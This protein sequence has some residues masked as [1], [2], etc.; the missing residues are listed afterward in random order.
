MQNISTKDT[1]LLVF[2]LSAGREAER[3]PLFGTKKKKVSS[4]F[5]KLL[6]KDTA[7]LAE[8]S[9]V[10]VFWIDE[11]KQRGDDFA[12]RFTHAFEDLYAKGY[13]NVLSIGNDC[14]ELTIDRLKTAIAQLKQNK[15]VLGPAEDGGAYLLGFP[16]EHFDGF[17]FKELPW[18]QDDLYEEILLHTKLNG[19]AYHCLD[20]LADIDS[21]KDVLAFAERNPASVAAQYIRQQLLQQYS[22]FTT[23]ISVNY[24]ETYTPSLPAR[25][26]PRLQMTA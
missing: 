6:I 26:P 17:P 22:S 12:S 25:A 14:P 5:F 23:Y 15:T 20:P 7:L 19:T 11:N 4:D 16:K 3:K 13:A 9:G 8:A 1:A 24:T 21:Q 2:S 18:Q 10:D